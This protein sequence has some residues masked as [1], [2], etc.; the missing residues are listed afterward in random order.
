MFIVS[1]R[2]IYEIDHE[3]GKEA[4]I[5]LSHQTKLGE[6][7]VRLQ[8]NHELLQYRWCVA[9]RILRKD[10]PFV[11]KPESLSKSRVYQ[12]PVPKKAM[13]RRLK[14]YPIAV[15]SRWP[16]SFQRIWN[17]VSWTLTLSAP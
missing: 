13:A 17:S 3:S 11:L 5:E 12:L 9:G 6:C 8:H 1:K 4:G 2:V 15:A 14:C 10:R 16:F 7:L